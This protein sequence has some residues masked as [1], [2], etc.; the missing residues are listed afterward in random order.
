MICL[1]ALNYRE[2]LAPKTCPGVPAGPPPLVAD[3]DEE[4]ESLDSD[5]STRGKK[6]RFA[7]EDN[8]NS[9]SNQK[10]KEFIS[11]KPILLKII[12][13]LPK[14]IDPMSYIKFIIFRNSLVKIKVM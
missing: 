1:N 13:N 2:S 7:A 10:V 12:F 14:L 3:Y 4:D 5:V 6:I 9:K 11:K 8:Q